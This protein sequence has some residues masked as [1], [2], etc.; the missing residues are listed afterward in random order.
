MKEAEGVNAIRRTGVPGQPPA[1]PSGQ[2]ERETSG[3]PVRTKPQAPRPLRWWLSS[4]FEAGIGC[5]SQ[6]VPHCDPLTPTDAGG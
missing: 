2:R 1:G 4:S 5:E 3:L 6:E